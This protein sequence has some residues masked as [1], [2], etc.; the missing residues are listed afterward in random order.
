MCDVSGDH[1]IVLDYDSAIIVDDITEFL[2]LETALQCESVGHWRSQEHCC[3]TTIPMIIQLATTHIC[4]I[5]LYAHV[6]MM[7]YAHVVSGYYCKLGLYTCVSVF[8]NHVIDDAVLLVL[9]TP[10]F[11]DENDCCSQFFG[12]FRLCLRRLDW[13]YWVFTVLFQC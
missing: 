3:N 8:H 4:I 6:V 13:V 2:N 11:G 7:L 9:T 10:H 1:E 12:H 5:L